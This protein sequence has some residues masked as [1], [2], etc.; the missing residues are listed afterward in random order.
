MAVDINKIRKS[1]NI[2]G[3]SDKMNEMLF[4]VGQVAN[5]DISVLIT[6]ASHSSCQMY[7]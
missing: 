5:T 4:M 2:I 3:T 1:A 6:G 7:Q